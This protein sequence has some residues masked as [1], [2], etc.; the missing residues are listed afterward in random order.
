MT[1]QKLKMLLVL[2]A[3]ALLL[4][5]GI[6]SA[7]STPDRQ[8]ITLPVGT[9]FYP[10][11]SFPQMVDYSIVSQPEGK[12]VEHEWSWLRLSKVGEYLLK[13]RG[14]DGTVCLELTVHASEE[15][16]ALLGVTIAEE[17][18]IEGLD[19]R[20]AFPEPGVLHVW[21]EESG[22]EVTELDGSV[23]GVTVTELDGRVL[24]KTELRIDLEGEE[25][26]DVL[27]RTMFGG[28]EVAIPARLSLAYPCVACGE[29]PLTADYNRENHVIGYC[30]HWLCLEVGNV[31][32]RKCVCG[33][34]LCNGKNHD[35]C[36]CPGCGKYVRSAKEHAVCANC[37]KRACDA[38]YGDPSDH[39]VCEH[40]GVIPCTLSWHSVTHAPC[41][42][43]GLWS[44][45][46]SYGY[47]SEH[48]ACP[49]CG[50]MA[51]SAEYRA[52]PSAHSY[53]P[54]CGRY[55]CAP[56]H[57][58]LCPYCSASPC[59]PHYNEAQH[60]SFCE[61]CGKRLCLGVHG[62]CAG[63]SKQLCD[64]DFARSEHVFCE[65]CDMMICEPGYVPGEHGV[66]PYC[67]EPL[68]AGNHSACGQTEETEETC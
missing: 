1:N 33:E 59:S 16:P 36:A 46:D 9:R 2:L 32:N 65:Y 68:C 52:N 31:H 37:G 28:K 47:P 24:G 58:A 40:C 56:D 60:I 62:S 21:A 30:G 61:N 14:A 51:C 20:F 53:D 25:T 57:P 19:F 35:D 63:C 41:P 39:V 6:A 10:K 26:K 23:P 3:A 17:D 34:Y 55:T 22:A 4:V 7:E 49:G 54:F 15:A 44:C 67:D 48:S 38:S 27:L 5:C 12:G 43:C 64:G 45:D 8:E 11:A 66:C 18:R 50:L 13:G 42:H 29:S